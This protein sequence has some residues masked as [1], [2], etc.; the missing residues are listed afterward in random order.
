MVHVFTG[1]KGA[2]VA[3]RSFADWK[4]QFEEAS[5]TL[6]A[7]TL[8]KPGTTERGG[9]AAVERLN[10]VCEQLKTLFATGA[11][12]KD[13]AAMVASGRGRVSAAEARLS[14]LRAKQGA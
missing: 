14:I 7:F 12:A 13:A 11:N 1:Q 9:L 6:R 10:A 5:D 4:Q 3:K 8:G 2:A